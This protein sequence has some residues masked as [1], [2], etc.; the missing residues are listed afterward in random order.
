LK[1]RI[2]SSVP[3]LDSIRDI[4][5]ADYQN[6]QARELARQAGLTFY[7]TLTNGLAQ[8]KSFDA[9]CQETNVTP[10]KV[11]PF[12]LKTRAL[13]EIEAT[14]SLQELKNVAFN[15]VPGKTSTFVPSR[16]GGFILYVVARLPV[17]ADQL[18][19]ELASHMSEMRQERLYMAFNDW[20]NKETEK[21]KVRMPKSYKEAN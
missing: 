10:I 19:T 4:V 8:G 7:N 17:P 5:M 20:F 13:P 3:P 18:K 14:V 2:P 6:T 21:A 15:L 9:V 12:S 1:D 11:P 16:Q